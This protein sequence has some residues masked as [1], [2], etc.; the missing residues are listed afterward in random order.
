MVM[1]GSTPARTTTGSCMKPV[2]RLAG[3]TLSYSRA[4]R[5]AREAVI[6]K[7]EL[8]THTRS[9]AYACIV[10]SFLTPRFSVLPIIAALTG[11]PPVHST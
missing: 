9:H 8:R 1:H 3:K 4:K 2:Q 5:Q 6:G 10:S 7:D 11:Y